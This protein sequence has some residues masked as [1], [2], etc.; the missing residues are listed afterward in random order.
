MEYKERKRVLFFGLP[1][2]FTKYMVTED[3]ITIDEGILKKV[4]NDCY[5]YKVQDVTLNNSLLE[6]IFGLGTVVCH[7]GDTTHPKLELVHIKNAREIKDYILVA[8]EQAR[9]KRRTMNML[10]IGA[11]DDFDLPDDR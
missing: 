7:T 8:S 1:W 5:M 10:D 2:T 11:G 3:L 9:M 6:R 4:E